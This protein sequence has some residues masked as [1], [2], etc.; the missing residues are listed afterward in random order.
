MQGG[1]LGRR[2]VSPGT[3]IMVLIG[4]CVA[5]TG[6]AMAMMTSAPMMIEPST[7]EGL[8]RKFRNAS[9]QRLAE[10]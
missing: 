7:A 2:P 8:W 3:P 9:S 4:S 6:A 1:L 10:R 5:K